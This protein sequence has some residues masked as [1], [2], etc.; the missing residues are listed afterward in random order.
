MDLPVFCF[1]CPGEDTTD[2]LAHFLGSQAWP[3]MNLTLEGPLGAG[4]TIFA[5]GFARGLGIEEPITSPSYPIIQ[6]YRGRLDFHHMDWY[7]LGSE[8]EVLETGALE[9]LDSRGVSLVEWPDR[10]L[11]LFDDR[12]LRI[13]IAIEPDQSRLVRIVIAAQETLARLG[14]PGSLPADIA[15]LRNNKTME[16]PAGLAYLAK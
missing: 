3:G 1:R 15:A 6:E 16:G 5:R 14:W 4:K 12:A 7:R 10:A 8:D 11:E 9:L 13:A 2:R